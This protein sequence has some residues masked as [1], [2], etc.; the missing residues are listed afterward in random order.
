MQINNEILYDFIH[1]QYKAYRKSK[2]QRG[3]IPDYKIFYN[4]LKQTQKSNFE[5]NLSEN[6][7]PIFSNVF[8]DS[9]IP[10]DGYALNLNFKNENIDLAVDGVEFT[11]KKNIIPIF[12]T[13]FEKVTKLDKLF[14]ALQ[15]SFI[16][17]E[18]NLRVENCKIIFGK[19]TR[20]TKFK[21]SSFTS[22][23]KKTIG[24]LNKTLSNTNAPTFFKNRHCQVCEF[25][26]TC[27]EKLVERDDL[28]LLAGLKPK[29]IA[30]R[31][32]RGVFSVKQ[33]SYTFRPKKHPYRKRKFL[34]ELKALAIRE[35][36]TFIQEIPTI[37]VSQN[38]IFFDIEGL[39]DRNIYYLI[40]VIIRAN[41][42][43]N[44][45]SFWATNEDE[46]KNIFVEF[47]SL[48]QSL[49]EFTA[50]HYG[51]YE[52]QALKTIS[53]NLTT[54]Q[55]VF[56]KKIIDNSFNILNIFTNNIYPPTYSNSLKDI[57]RFLKFD[58]SEKDA[59]GLQSTVW[60][61]NW[62]ISNSDELKNKL[63]IYNF[64]DCRALMVVKDWIV[65]I[66]NNGN[67]NFKK[68]ETIKRDSI[69]KWQRNNFLVEELNQINRFAYFNYQRE[70]VYIKTYPKIAAQQKSINSK[71]NRNK[72]LKH[73]KIIQFPRPANCPRCN[74]T[75]CW[76][77]N[78]YT[79]TVVDLKITKT[80]IRRHV[81]SYHLNVFECGDCDFQFTPDDSLAIRSKYVYILMQSVPPIL[82]QSV[83]VILIQSVPVILMQSVPPFSHLKCTNNLIVF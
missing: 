9:I 43:E 67:E 18:F 22:I 74:G 25:Q 70:K 71:R 32:N 46:K 83:P 55:Q 4:Q 57:A 73:N 16:Q 28:S 52:T 79:R 10:K 68:A 42:V 40:G 58:W 37:P 26:N 59:S 64:E 47:I 11:D 15:A 5:K 63:I 69:F 20:Q 80:M 41:G 36:K 53:K 33:L 31:N 8:I 6:A 54:E 65:N 49:D 3:I 24:D 2:Q 23:V 38:E 14:V 76:K 61:Y 78:K 66:P 27:L 51:S 48:L 29:D 19:N 75:T 35:A 81:I 17:N 77:H 60:R 39:P 72:S 7:K 56:L 21:L 50:Y 30:Q 12:I 82:M 34:P 13:P 62:E 44:T 1:C 45:Y